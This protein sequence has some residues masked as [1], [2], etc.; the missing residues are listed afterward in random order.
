MPNPSQEPPAS[1]NVPNQDLNDME[2]L[3]T[4]KTKIEP[5]FGT[6]VYH[7]LAT[8][9]KPKS[10]LQTPESSKAPNEDLKDMY[11]L[12]TFKIMLQS[13][14][15]DQGFIKYQ[16]PYPYKDQ[17]AK[18]Q[19]GT[20]SILHSTKWGLKGHGCSLHLQ[21]Q[22][23]EPKFGSWMCQTLVN[24]SKSIPGCQTPVRNLQGPPKPQM[25]A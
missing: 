6:W 8:I 25:R 15:L 16:W 14:T 4:F 20:S 2:V 18:P 7:R 10:K 24:I 22:D 11:V 9:S 17:D 12:C 5:K 21:N 3:F 23:R 13:K 19:S 1:F